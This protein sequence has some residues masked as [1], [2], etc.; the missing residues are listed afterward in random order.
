MYV[1]GTQRMSQLIRQP[2]DLYKAGW[3]DHYLLGLAN[4]PA[5][6]VDASV[7]HEVIIGF[8][9]HQTKCSIR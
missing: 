1:L 4:R 8:L 6:A 5:H 7:S 2:F 9:V 3:L